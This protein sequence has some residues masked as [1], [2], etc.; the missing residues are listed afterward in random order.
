MPT[1]GLVHFPRDP[2][3]AYFLRTRVGTK[4]QRTRR[5]LERGADALASAD[6]VAGGRLAFDATTAALESWLGVGVGTV[7]GRALRG[8][9]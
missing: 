8:K 4:L 6:D 5:A 9:A 3:A 2:R 1:S 7:R